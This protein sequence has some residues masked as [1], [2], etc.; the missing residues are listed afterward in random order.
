MLSGGSMANQNYT[1]PGSA[2]PPQE[3]PS[4]P[5]HQKISHAGQSAHSPAKWLVILA[6]ALVWV[7][8]GSTYLAIRWAVEVFPPYMMAGSRFLVAG[9]ILYGLTRWR[10]E[11][12]AP[13]SK[14][15]WRNAAIIGAFLLVGA[16]GSVT[17]AE[18]W[19]PSGLAALIIASA[20]FWMVLLDWLQPGGK[21]PSAAVGAGLV[22][23]FAGMLILFWGKE[24]VRADRQIFI[25]SI[26]ILLGALSWSFGSILS[27]RLSHPA[28][29]GLTTAM[30]MLTAGAIMF[31]IGLA[32]GEYA[33]ISW[34][35][36]HLMKAVGSFWFLVVAGSLLGFT[37]YTF[38]LKV[39]TPAKVATYAYVN[40]LVAVLLGATLGQEIISGRMLVAAGL[41]LGAVA[42]IS[43]FRSYRAAKAV[44]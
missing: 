16:N 28:S 35:H 20:A 41:I 18:K 37:S 21:R 10:G 4:P 9:V 36:D 32:R 24:D 30:Q 38:I 19:V 31:L 44:K 3:E 15:H 39:S 11:V 42:L 34:G 13:P 1:P 12:P 5:S 23:G 8:W 33:Q 17:W 26:A 6:F 22:V 40:P 43:T 2:I 27:R 14:I 7:C 29:S 25:G